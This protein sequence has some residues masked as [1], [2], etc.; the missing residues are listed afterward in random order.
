MS[1]LNH[2][3]V[4]RAAMPAPGLSGNER[5]KPRREQATRRAPAIADPRYVGQPGKVL[6]LYAMVATGTF[7]CAVTAGAV[8]VF[9]IT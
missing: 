7:V 9:S 8:A 3:A 5:H 4:S 1:M 2:M 6:R